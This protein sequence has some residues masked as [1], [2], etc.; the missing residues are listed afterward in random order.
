[1]AQYSIETST[2]LLV[3]AARA[4]R[5]PLR[6]ISLPVCRRLTMRVSPLFPAKLALRFASEVSPRI[7]RYI[8]LG[9]QT[10]G[11]KLYNFR[12][13]PDGCC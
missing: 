1:M 4:S 9:G 7:R 6:R 3:D 13:G 2:D 8:P 12:P 5:Q 11:E 10:N